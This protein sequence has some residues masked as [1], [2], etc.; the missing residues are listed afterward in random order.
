MAVVLGPALVLGLAEVVLRVVGY[1]YHPHLTV[2]C[3]VSGAPYRGDNVKFAWRFFPPV[4]AREFEPFAFPAEKPADTYRIFVLGASAAQ[5]VPN[6]AF[7]FGRFLKLMLEDQFHDR[8]FEVITTAMAAINSHVVL[9]VAR[10]CARYDPDLFVVYLGNNEVVGPYG[11]GTV[12]SPVLSNLRLI[13]W[14]IALRRTR[15]GQFLSRA[16]AGRG[17][18][19][20]APDYWRG[21]EM[22]VGQQVRADDP[23]LEVVYNHFRRNL[24]DICHIAAGAGAET[25]LCTVGS[26][27][28]DSPPFASLHRRDLT[29]P[30]KER[31]QEAYGQGAAFE[32]EGRYDQAIQSYLSADAID[33]SHADLQFRLGRCHER[34]SEYDAAG[35]RYIQAR[36]LDALRFRA[37]TRINAVIRAVAD[38]ERS[39]GVRCADVV[40]ALSEAGGGAGPGEES[41]H[42]HVHLTF[43][44]NYLVARTVAQ[45]VES[46]LRDR[47]G[48]VGAEAEV[49]TVEQC[50]QRLVQSD[51]SRHETLETVVHSFLS[52]PPFTNQLYHEERVAVLEQRLSTLKEGL[53]GES[54]RSIG[55]QF[56]AAIERAPGDWRLRWDYGKL[57]AEDLKEYDAAAAQYRIVQGWL[58]HSHMGH[59]AL[60]SV[61]LAQGELDGAIAECRKALAIKPTSGAVYY[62]LGW[63]Y[64]KQGKPDAAIPQYR[65]AIRFA[66]NS[67]SA[68]LNLGELLFRKGAFA[69]AAEVCRAGLAVAPDHP[70]LHCNLGMLSI[71]MGQRREGAE[72]IARALQLD[73]NSPRIRKVAETLLGPGASR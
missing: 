42:E 48:S 34:L 53:T 56:Q 5:G 10:D 54:L 55:G 66:P 59:D 17:P 3:E 43:Q 26:N 1:G 44:G 33:D 36:D 19:G 7:C 41:F 37:D 51:W 15:A 71:K 40:A 24:E 2:P 21:M 39:F 28:R 25:I 61:L 12:L 45:Q 69:E 47:A 13:R 50:A 29:E 30:Q 16:V 57:L 49:P 20:K 8:D 68:Y 62:H 72:E 27:L 67:T 4:L 58:P 35:A 18:A 63:C 23:R 32:S 73:P 9:E 52:R 64:Q 11:P 46:V 38:G 6:H 14:G 65:Q 22:F 70:L 60:A 31:W